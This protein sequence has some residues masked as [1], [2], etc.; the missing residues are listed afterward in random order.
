MITSSNWLT[1]SWYSISKY[2]PWGDFLAVLWTTIGLNHKGQQKKLESSQDES[3][4]LIWVL[5][6]VCDFLLLSVCAFVS[7]FSSSSAVFRSLLQKEILI[8]IKIKQNISLLIR[9]FHLGNGRLAKFV[10]CNLLWVNFPHEDQRIWMKAQKMFE[11]RFFPFFFLSH[12]DF[13]FILYLESVNH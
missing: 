10:F 6:D 5:I 12:N 7:S 8:S 1:D 4:L 3:K 13:Q 2:W 9:S 11:I